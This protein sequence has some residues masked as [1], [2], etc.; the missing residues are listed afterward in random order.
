MS[1]DPNDALSDF[2]GRVAKAHAGGRFVGYLWVKVADVEWR[3][4]R[5]RFRTTAVDMILARRDQS[6]MGHWEYSDRADPDDADALAELP[7]G[8]VDWYGEILTLQ[9]L[10]ETEGIRIKREVFGDK[11]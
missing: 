2:N 11:G 10:N 6:S 1:E 5:E 3:N 4:R 9:W 8:E 7:Q